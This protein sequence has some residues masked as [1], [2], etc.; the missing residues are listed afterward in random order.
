LNTLFRVL[1]WVAVIGG[2]IC[3]IV[4]FAYADVWTLPSDDP[5]LLASVEPTLRGGDLVLV[6]R[7]GSPA[8]GDVVR[9][10]D[11]DEPRRW[12]VGRLVGVGGADL[13][14]HGQDFQLSG[15]RES[16]EANCGTVKMSNP[17]TGD[18][19]TLTCRNR[20]FAGKEYSTLHRGDVEVQAEGAAQRHVPP[21]Q[22][23]LISDN[24]YLHLDSR[25]FG[26]VQEATCSRI[27]FRLWGASGFTDGSRRF[28]FIW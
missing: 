23:F 19:V 4:Y 16:S 24:R 26:S 28:N 22:I 14:L 13:M 18:D 9:C 21:G 15:S 2:A 12:V 3:A 5:R 6:A 25:D 20:E 11:P 1:A 8:L 17:A 27:L 10:P 7:H